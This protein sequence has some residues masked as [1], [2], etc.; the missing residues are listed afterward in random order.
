MSKEIKPN[1]HM[2]E[3]GKH[4]DFI[5][6]LSISYNGKELKTLRYDLGAH[7]DDNGKMT[8]YI[9]ER[10]MKELYLPVLAHFMH[11]LRIISD[12]KPMDID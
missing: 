11:R 4:T 10:S 8:E 12:V 9:F 3:D 5:A 6:S 1:I 2:S 7:C